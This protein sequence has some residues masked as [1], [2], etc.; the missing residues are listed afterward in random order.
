MAGGEGEEVKYELGMIR[1]WNPAENKLGYGQLIYVDELFNAEVNIAFQENGVRGEVSSLAVGL[2][3]MFKKDDNEIFAE[4]I[5]E[6]KED[7]FDVE[8]REVHKSQIKRLQEEVIDIETVLLK[9]IVK[10]YD[11]ERGEIV[12]FGEFDHS[13]NINL[14]AIFS[15]SN[16]TIANAKLE[17]GD[18]VSFR[19]SGD[20]LVATDVVKMSDLRL[21]NKGEKE[22]LEKLM[23]EIT[24]PTFA[25]FEDN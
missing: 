25:V 17:A 10:C 2:L 7:Q 19:R 15:S 24:S 9:G 6:W 18:F 20:N 3:V 22:A 21:F 1:S 11:G 13:I 8:T 14:T 23:E 5:Y 16:V 4:D 12:F